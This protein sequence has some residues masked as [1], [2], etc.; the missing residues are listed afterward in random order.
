MFEQNKIN[1][2]F[3]KSC[4]VL[5]SLDNYKSLLF[6]TGVGD[7][8]IF[9]IDPNIGE[10]TVDAFR[11]GMMIYMYYYPHLNFPHEL[12][13]DDTDGSVFTFA[14]NRFHPKFLKCVL[15]HIKLN[16]EF[17]LPFLPRINSSHW[18]TLCIQPLKKRIVILNP[19][20]NTVEEEQKFL[21]NM[22]S[23][24]INEIGYYFDTFIENVG[25]QESSMSCGENSLMIALSIITNGE[26]GY[27]NLLNYFNNDFK[28]NSILDIYSIS[29]N[30]KCSCVNCCN[31]Y[32][33]IE[34]KTQ[35]C[36]VEKYKRCIKC[37][38][39]FGGSIGI[40]HIDAYKCIYCD[41]LL[42][43]DTHDLLT[44]KKSLNKTQ[45]ELAIRNEILNVIENESLDNL[46]KG[47]NLS[48]ELKKTKLELVKMMKKYEE[49]LDKIF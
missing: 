39:H 14:N 15:D 30:T 44:I 27:I 37:N 43:F 5:K 7:N 4:E 35:Q 46:K 1:T 48:E 10:F 33:D 9:N 34:M 18:Y 25:L 3:H 26:S 16:K 6:S 11:I 23:K 31:C 32:N 29:F 47:C 40:N 2:Y 21:F 13:S 45:S 24:L 36:I 28:I 12:L 8:M 41:N 22:I 20:N 42:T 49:L 38:E 19:L 17:I